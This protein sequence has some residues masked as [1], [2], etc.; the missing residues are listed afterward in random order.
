MDFPWWEHFVAWRERAVNDP[1]FALGD[2]LL[3]LGDYWGRW[4]A[5]TGS[6]KFSSEM[7]ACSRSRE[8]QQNFVEQYLPGWVSRQRKYAAYSDVLLFIRHELA[9]VKPFQTWEA[10]RS[11]RKS[12]GGQ[13]ALGVF[14]PNNPELQDRPDNVVKLEYV[15]LPAEAGDTTVLNFAQP[16]AYHNANTVARRFLRNPIFAIL[17]W[18]VAGRHP[19]HAY[20]WI[21]TTLWLVLCSGIAFLRFGPDWGDSLSTLAVLLCLIWFGLVAAGLLST[22]F[23]VWPALVR[24]NADAARDSQVFLRFCRPLQGGEHSF[25]L[26]YAIAILLA[27]LH[28]GSA[29]KAWLW[30]SIIDHANLRRDSTVWTG[31]LEPTGR[32]TKVDLFSKIRSCV[33]NE[34]IQ[35]MEIP[36]QSYEPKTRL[37]FQKN[38]HYLWAV[39]RLGNLFSSYTILRSMLFIT[40][41]LT[42]LLFWR[43]DLFCLAW[44]PSAPELTESHA[45]AKEVRLQF[46]GDCQTCAYYLDFESSFFAPRLGIPLQHFADSKEMEVK[47][48]LVQI[49]EKGTPQGVFFIRRP[50]RLGARWFSR[51][52]EYI[53]SLNGIQDK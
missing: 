27:T 13:Y 11:Y 5:G 53:L 4:Y 2:P 24:R 19:F 21:T 50:R 30:R 33:H 8:V 32:V 34:Q 46:K 51:R 49:A 22:L 9:H 15:A 52:T 10:L 18:M 25:G 23:V 48:R 35:L 20:D 29:S 41:A 31:V 17:L 38:W 7:E 3:K 44:E 6:E 28:T 26:L 42:F 1:H 16:N 36:F 40:T 45:D 14:I 12:F 43:T 47:I 39:F 37:R